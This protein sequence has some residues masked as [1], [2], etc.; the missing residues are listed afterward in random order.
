MRIDN[1]DDVLWSD[2]RTGKQRSNWRLV[3]MMMAIVG[4]L[5]CP[6][7][8]SASEDSPSAVL[9][10]PLA[11]DGDPTAA[12][13]SPY[14]LH[15]P[16]VGGFLWADG[17][18]MRGLTDGLSGWGVGYYDWTNGDP[19][20]AAL[21]DLTNKNRQKQKVAAWIQQRL[22]DHPDQTLTLIAH[23]GGCAIA[24]WALEQ[25]PQAAQIDQLILLAPA[26][27]P[28]YDLTRALRHVRTRA[29]VFV[30]DQDLVLGWGTQVAGTMDGAHTEAA[31]RVGFVISPQADRLEYAKLVSMS[32][33]PAWQEL[34]NAGDHIGPMSY[35]FVRY[36]IAPLIIS[37][38]LPSQ[39]SIAAAL[40]SERSIPGQQ[41]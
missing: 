13:I 3:L 7:G 33:R 12:A 24:V 14:V 26:L 17:N 27:S 28:E 23:S 1:G 40:A 29:W 36:F 35:L 5:V 38:Q 4:L 32:Y 39:S 6:V 31:G 41:N 22:T 20:L 34:D 15:L 37:G 19:G 11:V 10:Q 2:M 9:I 30:S 18:L 8:L 21:H 25:L 16:G